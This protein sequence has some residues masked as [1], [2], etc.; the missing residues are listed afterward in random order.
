MNRIVL[1][2]SF[3]LLSI[4]P[5]VRPSN[6]E[7]KPSLISLQ[8]VGEAAGI[9][10]KMRC[11]AP[12]KPWIMD[13]NGSGAAWLDYDN[14]G[15]MDLLIV[16]GSNLAELR[17]ILSGS[18]PQPQN[19]GVYLYHNLGNGHFQDVTDKSGLF[20]PY[21]G[22]GAN[23]SDFDNDGFTDILI[24]AIGVDLLFR[25][26]HDGTFSEIGK[27]VGLKQEIAWHTGSAFGDYDGDGKL[28][29][30]IAGY[31]NIKA[32][33]LGSAPPVCRYNGITGFCGP[34]GLRGEAD[35]LYH[36]N[37]DGTFKDVTQEA[38][39]A[40][41]AQ[42]YGFAVV[43][44]DFNGDGKL[45]FFVA[46]DS[47]PNYLY[48][49][50][51]N[52][53][54]KEAAMA[55]G[56]AVNADGR[57]QTNMGAAVGDYD[58]DGK[59]DLL[60]TTFSEDYY[61]LYHQ[62]TPGLYEDVALDAG[63]RQITLA[64]LGWGCGFTDLDNDGDKDI[65]TANGHVY[66]NA[67]QLKSTSY[68][69]TIAIFENRKAKFYPTAD[70]LGS[71]YHS[72][73]R[74]GASGDFDNDG[75]VDLV[76]LPIEGRPILL[77]NKAADDSS[78]ISLKLSGKG[79]NRDAIGSKIELENCGQKQMDTLRNGGSYISRNDPR[80]HFGLGNC[81]TVDRIIITWPCGKVQELKNL[82]PNQYLSVQ[83]PD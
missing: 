79:C 27:K 2:L 65:W 20:N 19:E 47:C 6:P 62:K 4:A 3:V 72:S 82:K 37:G 53:T 8:D 51:G 71:S 81:T 42:Y 10:A 59:I 66:P 7:S 13:A 16:N 12:D 67:N 44:D 76:V 77:K 41:F 40:D 60:I 14:D 28:D 68:L 58:N 33:P 55:S 29:L 21:W 52:G 32:L 1:L 11:G 48:L 64:L 5:Q 46:N 24:T 9:L 18:P 50:Q 43:A 56:V 74:S 25:N 26:N 73:Y 57:A 30:Y 75:K 17:K 69:Q 39:V 63:L 45:D 23:A 80:V 38:G 31:V 83:E 34:R 22:T 15:W 61:P 54:F 36:N 78:W 49:N 35:I 70:P